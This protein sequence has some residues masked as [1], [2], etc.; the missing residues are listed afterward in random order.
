MLN[1]SDESLRTTIDRYSLVHWFPGAVPLKFVTSEILYSILLG[2]LRKMRELRN[3]KATQ[4]LHLLLLLSVIYTSENRI[5]CFK[6][7]SA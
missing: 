1:A 3:P 6:N 4:M 2:I 5:N 7:S